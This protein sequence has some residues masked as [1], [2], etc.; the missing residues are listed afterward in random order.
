MKKRLKMA[1]ATLT[2]VATVTVGA[3][4][5]SVSASDYDSYSYFAELGAQVWWNGNNEYISLNLG[6]AGGSNSYL[7]KYRVSVYPHKSY[8]NQT[9][10]QFTTI[11][12]TCKFNRTDSSTPFSFTKTASGKTKLEAQTSGDIYSTY[13]KTSGTHTV[14][15]YRTG[16]MSANGT[17]SITLVSN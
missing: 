3:G 8:S 14:T 9:Q 15:L 7:S 2:A 16:Y 11:T 13:A 4:N 1:L 17:G 5:L 6:Y 10:Y 12:A